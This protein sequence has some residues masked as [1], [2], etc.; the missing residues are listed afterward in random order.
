M[1]FNVSKKEIEDISDRLDE[2][3][4]RLTHP[5]GEPMLPRTRIVHEATPPG[6]PIGYRGS[7]CGFGKLGS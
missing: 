5:D 6:A 3:E 2:I 7:R 4:W 1:M